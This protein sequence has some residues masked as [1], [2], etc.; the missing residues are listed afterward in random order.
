MFW[1]K[2]LIT[3]VMFGFTLTL[4]NSANAA[5]TLVHCTAQDK[6][7]ELFVPYAQ[8]GVNPLVGTIRLS[9]GAK[10]FI[11]ASNDEVVNYTN[12]IEELS[13]SVINS[14]QKVVLKANF[15]FNQERN[16]YIGSI[17]FKG[18]RIGMVCSA[19]H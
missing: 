2:F 15:G 8:G 13:F 16:R 4:A 17:L 19:E 14:A 7:L 12:S 18:L 11:E 1:K 6:G 10:N 5:I 3:S 9:H